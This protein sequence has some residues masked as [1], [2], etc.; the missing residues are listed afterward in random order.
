KEFAM[1]DCLPSAR[2]SVRSAR[3]ALRLAASLGRA[4]LE[5][6]EQCI[7]AFEICFP[8]LPE[9][10]DPGTRLRERPGFDPPRP[11]LRVLSDGNERC[12]LENSQVFRDGGLADPE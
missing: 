1:A 11:A 9:S 3:F 12:P 4:A 5:L 6:R 7:Q 2:W 8:D 10:F